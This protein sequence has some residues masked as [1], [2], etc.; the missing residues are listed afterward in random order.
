MK[1]ILTF[2]LFNL[3]LCDT[4]TIDFNVKGMMC[5][6]GC[7]KKIE[8]ELKS[9]EG[10]KD[11]NVSFEKSNVNITYDDQFVTDKIIIDQLNTNT[12][13]SF[14]LKKENSFMSFFKNLF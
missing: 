8:N 11:F 5:G 6:L 12:T 14:N 7:V 1:K 10:V 13:Y 4:Q 2:L 9:I 3:I